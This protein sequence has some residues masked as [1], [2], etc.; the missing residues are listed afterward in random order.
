MPK[1][2]LLEM[3]ELALSIKAI[4]YKEE[5]A[6]QIEGKPSNKSL[7]NSN[8]IAKLKMAVQLLIQGLSEEAVCRILNISSVKFPK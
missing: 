2:N 4:Q 6:K 5:I 7:V 1:I 3:N 8:E